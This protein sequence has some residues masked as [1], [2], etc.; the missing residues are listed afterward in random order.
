MLR[1]S[2]LVLVL[3][4]LAADSA[5]AQAPAAAL[6]RTQVVSIQPLFALA[7]I[8]AGEYERAVSPAITLGVGGTAWG[9]DAINYTSVELKARYYPQERALTGLSVGAAVGY[10]RVGE[11]LGIDRD[12][13]VSAPSAGA[14]IEYGWLLGSDRRLYAGVGFG[15]KALF[16]D[17][18]R[19]SD[20]DFIARYPT[21]RVSVGYAF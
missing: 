9:I 14:L 12:L 4:A 1:R 20:E 10:S 11:N 5:R 7:A 2:A 3:S 16:I 19:F 6:R 17:E 21:A 18:D 13:N 15:A 8:F